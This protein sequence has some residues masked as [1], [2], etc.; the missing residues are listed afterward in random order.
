L[1]EILLAQRES[2]GRSFSWLVLVSV[3]STTRSAAVLIVAEQHV[4]GALGSSHELW[5]SPRSF[6]VSLAIFEFVKNF[7]SFVTTV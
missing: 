2:F 3:A 1:D 5:I 7:F 4:F 6:M